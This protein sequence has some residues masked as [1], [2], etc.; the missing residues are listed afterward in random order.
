MFTLSTFYRS[1]EW[2][3]LRNQLRLERVNNTGDVICEHC[4]KPILKAYDCIAHHIVP[5][6]ESNVNNYNISLNPENIQLVHFRCHNRIHEKGFKSKRV[7][8]VYGSPCSGKSYYVDSVATADDLI[9]DID[10]IYNSINSSRSNKL[11]NTVMSTYRHLLDIVKTRNGQWHNA[12]IV[13]GFPYAMERQRLADSLD[14]ELIFIDTDKQTC[15]ERSKEKG[16]EYYK[17]VEDWFNK[18]QQ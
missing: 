16:S 15:L 11:L 4:F 7:Y 12:Y 8:I 5:L 9:I 6:T 17:F 14:A 10:R 2:E 1:K 18:Y 3:L 13:R